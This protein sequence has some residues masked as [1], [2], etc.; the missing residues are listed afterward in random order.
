MAARNGQFDEAAT[1]PGWSEAREVQVTVVLV[2][3]WEVLLGLRLVGH[4]V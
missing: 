2:E 3:C 1:L 4:H